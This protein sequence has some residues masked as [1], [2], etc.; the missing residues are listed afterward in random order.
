[1]SFEYADALEFS[2]KNTREIHGIILRLC[3]LIG[4]NR[5]DGL[6]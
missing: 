1:M 6:N 4:R 5:G 2:I 3:N